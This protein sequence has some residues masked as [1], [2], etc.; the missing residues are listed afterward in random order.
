MAEK[1]QEEMKGSGLRVKGMTR[2]LIRA[3][4][5]TEKEVVGA[6]ATMLSA[7]TTSFFKNEKTNG[8]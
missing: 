8:G 2:G 7:S 5:E 3:I 6:T 1:L 4:K